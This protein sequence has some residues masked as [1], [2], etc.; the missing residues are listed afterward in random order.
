MSKWHA[1][2]AH[3]ATHMKMMGG[4]FWLVARVLG[5]FP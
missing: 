4:P 3:T 5:P 2:V 1:N